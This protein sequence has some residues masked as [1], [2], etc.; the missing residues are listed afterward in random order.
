MEDL[1]SYLENFVKPTIAEFELNPTSI[2]H[3]FIACVV[4]FHAVDYLAF[5]KPARTLRQ[6]WKRKSDA[7]RIVDD[8][9][10]AFKHVRSGNPAV[11]VLTVRDVV[12]APG[13]FDPSAFSAAFDIGAVTM[14]REPGI[15]LLETVKKAALFLGQQLNERA[16]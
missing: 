7:F 10:H 2:R 4:T 9:A 13:A 8:V 5:P 14:E 1:E 15:N 12:T 11:A 6:E 3:A 16:T